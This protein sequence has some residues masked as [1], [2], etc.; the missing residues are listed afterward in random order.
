M[1]KLEIKG[2]KEQTERKSIANPGRQSSGD[3]EPGDKV[4]A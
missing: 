1:I 2:N 4:L 3:P